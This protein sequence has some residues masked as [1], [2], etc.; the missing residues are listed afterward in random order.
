MENEL[1]CL[2]N[3]NIVAKRKNNEITFLRKIVP[4]G[5]DDSFGI[6]VAKLAGLPSSV[7]S[8][9]EDILKDL[10]SGKVYLSEPSPRQEQKEDDSQVSFSQNFNEKI[11]DEL[12]N[13]DVTV[14]T[15]IEAMNELFRLSNEVKKNNV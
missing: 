10:D 5:T 1:T 9:A 15:P 6:D 11:I 3:F 2:K 12:L 14:L 13:L 7:I 8:R 4:G